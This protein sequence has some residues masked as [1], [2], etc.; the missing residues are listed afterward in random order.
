MD[1]KDEKNKTDK[2]FNAQKFLTKNIDKA[3]EKNMNQ[4][5]K[6]S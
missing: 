3:K 1:L 5:N 6:I 2:K 4:N